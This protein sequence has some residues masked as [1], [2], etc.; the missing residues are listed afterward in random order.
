MVYTLPAAILAAFTF[1]FVG[2]LVSRSGKVE[3]ETGKQ[4]WWFDAVWV[5]FMLVLGSFLFFYDTNS[6]IRNLADNFTGGAIGLG[7]AFLAHL[8]VR[9]L[10]GGRSQP[11]AER[12]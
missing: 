7:L 6:F 4:P 1:Y 8:L 3:R 2:L 5:P 9:R 11:P 12:D 10:R